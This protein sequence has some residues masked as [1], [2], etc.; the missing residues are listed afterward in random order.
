MAFEADFTDQ[1]GTTG[2]AHK[3]LLL[4]IKALA[5]L[6][7]WVTL[8]YATGVAPTV[9]TGLQDEL[10]LQ[11][12]GLAGTDQ[13]FIGFRT[14][15]NASAD[16]YNIAVAGFTGYVAANAWA[17]QPGFYESGIPAHNQRVDYWL[18]VNPRRINVGLKVGTPVYESGGAGFFLPYAK[19]SQYPYP[20]YVAGML[21]GAATTRYS[22][23]AHSMPWKGNRPNFVIRWLDGSFKQVQAYPWDNQFIG[24]LNA[25]GNDY[26]LRDTNNQY[27]VM[28]VVLCESAPANVFGKLDGV[29]FVSNFNNTVE[30]TVS[31]GAD[32][33]VCLQDVART[34]FNDYFALEMA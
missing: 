16:Y 18:Q 4:R 13:I 28:P 29:G 34:G 8:R 9:G 7:G 11:G 17:A 25:V 12:E 15:D 21:T 14:Y 10:I 22:D 27:P 6:N 24:G 32:D 1:T 30:S 23:T 31:D 26:V 19:P 3:E 2:F 33:W 20:L 5:E